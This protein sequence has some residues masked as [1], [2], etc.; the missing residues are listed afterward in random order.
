M[1]KPK[2][3]KVKAKKKARNAKSSKKT[4][5]GG[6][7]KKETVEYINCLLELHKLQGVMLNHLYADII[8]R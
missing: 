6:A 7:G 5:A 2:K 8:S 4:G 1:K 3:S